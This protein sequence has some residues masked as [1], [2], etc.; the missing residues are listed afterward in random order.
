M[1]SV[2]LPTLLSS[3]INCSEVFLNFFLDPAGEPGAG[4][5]AGLAR[6]DR[7]CQWLACWLGWLVWVVIFVGQPGSFTGRLS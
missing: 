1:L 4:L 6:P 7:L 3:P 2:S 5:G